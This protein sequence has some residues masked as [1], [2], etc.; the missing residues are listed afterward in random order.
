[1]QINFCSI[2][3]FSVCAMHSHG[4][5]MVLS[6]LCKEPLKVTPGVNKLL[7]LVVLSILIQLIIIY[8]NPRPPTAV[9]LTLCRRRVMEASAW[10]P[11]CSRFSP[12]WNFLGIFSCA[13]PGALP[14]WLIWRWDKWQSN[15]CLAGM[16]CEYWSHSVGLEGTWASL[17]RNWYSLVPH[18]GGVRYCTPKTSVCGISWLDC[19]PSLPLTPIHLPPFLTLQC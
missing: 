15:W 4:W 7:T 3:E 19:A 16:R 2:R 6:S 14:W 10:L 18:P 5:E 17:C 1:M 8:L 12:W 11:G 13:D 9:G